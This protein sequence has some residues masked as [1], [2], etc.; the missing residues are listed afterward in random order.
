MIN[1]KFTKMNGAGNDFV[2]IDSRDLAGHNLTENQVKHLCDRRRGAGADGLILIRPAEGKH[3]EMVYYNSDGR[4]GSLCGNGARCAIKF[5]GLNGYFDSEPASFIANGKEYKGHLR[6]SGLV[7]FHSQPPGKIKLDFK[8]K[9]YNQLITSHFA[10]TGSP[11][12]VIESREILSNPKIPSSGFSD[13]L[14]LPV[15]EIGKEIRYAKEFAPA[16]VNVNFIALYEE[17]IRLRT[18]ERG[19]EDETLACGTGSIAAAL[20]ANLKYG[21]ASPVNILTAG[22]DKLVVEFSKKAGNFSE[23]VLTGPAEINYT[24]FFEI[25]N[26]LTEK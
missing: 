20:I 7:S 15:T 8:I 23:I 13:L 5:A 16:G 24:G 21:M 17:H 1:F 18:Y 26:N 4:L 10:D 14:K 11:H 3:F 22:G 12:V 2:M 19:V 25:N 6:G 9:A